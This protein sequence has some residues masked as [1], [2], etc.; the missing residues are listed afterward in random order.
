MPKRRSTPSSKPGTG[1]G[2]SSRRSAR[3]A[4]Y[5]PALVAVVL[6]LPCL[7][8][9]YLWDDFDLVQQASQLSL[10]ALLPDPS[11]VFY[12]PISRVIFFWPIAKL[13]PQGWIGA[14]VFGFGLLIG[15]VML[16]QRLVA[17]LHGA[18]AGFYAGLLAACMGAVPM[19]VGWVSAAQDLLAI[20]FVLLALHAQLS[21]RWMLATLLAVL[22][23]LCKETAVILMPIVASARWFGGQKPYLLRRSWLAHAAPV[24]GWAVVHPGIRAL[25]SRGFSSGEAGYIGVH[26]SGPWLSIRNSLLCMLNLP[27]PGG[28]LEWPAWATLSWVLVLVLMAIA[29]WLRLIPT[30]ERRSTN[31]E[32]SQY[33]S[34]ALSMLLILLPIVATAL[35][36]RNWNPYYACFAVPG[37][38]LFLGPVLARADQALGHLALVVFTS[39][40]VLSRGAV[41][42]PSM[43]VE[44]NFREASGTLTRL[45]ANLKLA[46]PSPEPNSTLY[47]GCDASERS[48]IPQHLYRFQSPRTW[49]GDNSLK[50]RDPDQRTGGPGPEYLV[51]VSASERVALL[52]RRGA[53]DQ[54]LPA[55]EDPGGVQRVARRYAIGF[56]QSGEYERAAEILRGVP[57]P[58]D[59]PE[60]FNRRIARALLDAG[61]YS[62]RAAALR[63]SMRVLDSDTGAMLAIAALLE[64]PLGGGGHV[65]NV[66]Q[67]FDVPLDNEQTLRRLMRWFSG[68]GYLSMG[69]SI[70]TIL[71]R[72]RPGDEEAL[73]VDREYRS[74]PQKEKIVTPT[75]ETARPG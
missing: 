43:T 60:D 38:A 36:V 29:W 68:R 61:G 22:G 7:S 1:K 14:H 74:R 2:P 12:R 26:A 24:I 6:A 5:L 10:R 54:A 45:E 59:Y 3:W 42:D 4:G 31:L 62:A 48:G 55:G 67:A 15:A 8:I 32:N 70:G 20:F 19:L 53:V 11:V 23:V 56:A 72:I 37:M 28:A 30:S 16:T 33:R 35:L 44:R 57:Y 69:S 17:R 9:R 73:A 49:Y 21:G 58:A 27:L 75:D 51:W 13:G 25:V 63:D 39:L 64:M 65:A 47:V 34:V 66:L 41:V 18:R 50:T 52:G 46:V 71:L 40:G